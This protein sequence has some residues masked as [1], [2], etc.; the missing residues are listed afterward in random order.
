MP[1]DEWVVRWLAEEA[2]VLI[3]RAPQVAAG[4]LRGVIGQLRRSDQRRAVL[5]AS[6]VAALFRLRRYGEAERT[7]ARLLAGDTDPE[8]AAETAWLVGYA[9]IRTDR[10]A[11]AL[12]VVTRELGRQGLPDS[13]VARLRALQAIIL[14]LTGEIDRAEAAAQQALAEAGQAGTGSPPDTRCT[15]SALSASADGGRLRGW[16]SSTGRWR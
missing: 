4:L 13:P 7:G 14:N 9:M 12:A 2:P 5:E 15:A 10:R 1:A 3:Y 6:L 11:E 8:A 16:S